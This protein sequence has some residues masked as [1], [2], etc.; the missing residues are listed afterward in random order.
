MPDWPQISVLGN[1]FLED[2]HGIKNTQLK[3][4]LGLTL[5]SW[6][7]DGLH[8][9]MNR[10]P[11]L[12]TMYNPT[13]WQTAAEGKTY[14]TS[15]ISAVDRMDPETGQKSLYLAPSKAV[16]L[17]DASTGELRHNNCGFIV[18]GSVTELS[19]GDPL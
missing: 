9:M 13:G 10:M 12:T 3:P 7:A 15:G 17:L 16:Y 4:V 14:I 5:S 1:V 19:A 8:D 11:E 18:V 2:Y 6:H